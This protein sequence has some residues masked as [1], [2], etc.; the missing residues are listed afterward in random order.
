MKIAVTAAA[1]RPQRAPHVGRNERRA[2]T[3]ELVQLDNDLCAAPQAETGTT[4]QQNGE[5]AA[6]TALRSLRPTELQHY[7]RTTALRQDVAHHVAMHVGQA[8]VT[9]LKTIS[10]PR[11]IESQ[12]MQDGGLQVMHVDGILGNSES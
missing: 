6:V 5:T 11:V 1:C 7:A 3:A 2:V 9:P 12:Q 4:V 10:Q 8:I